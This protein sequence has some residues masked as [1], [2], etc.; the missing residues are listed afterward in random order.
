MPD[1]PTIFRFT[2]NNDH[3]TFNQR[4]FYEKNG[5]LIIPDLIPQRILDKCSKRYD[6]IISRNIDPGLIT[7]MRDVADRKLVNKIQ[8]INHDQVF[9]EY[10]EYDKLLDIVECITGPNIMAMHSMLIAKPPDAGYGSS[11]HPPHQDLH[12]FPFRPADK[13]VA[14]WTAIEPCNRSNGCL[15]VIPG[16]HGLDKLYEHDYPPG[17][18]PNTV[19]KFYYGIWDLP[20]MD[21]R[22]Y[23]VMKPGDTVF[24]HPLLIHGSGINRSNGSRK[25]ISCHYASSDCYYIEAKTPTEK[26]NQNEILMAFKKRFPNSNVTYEDIWR[27]KSKLVRG[28]R[29]SL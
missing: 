7:I 12:Y 1:T 18:K 23:I 20:P 4:L 17:S 24:F 25:A 15:Y 2:N 14:T 28:A 10:F 19:N 3:L 22:S 26:Q 21:D 13:I 11:S 9:E 5:F 27:L 16:T 6:D 29:S 8:N